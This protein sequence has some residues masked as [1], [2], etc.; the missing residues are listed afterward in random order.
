MRD[1]IFILE[2]HLVVI[3]IYII[4]YP[5]AP[6][7]SYGAGG[8]TDDI[9]LDNL[10]DL[11]LSKVYL[12]VN[13]VYEPFAVV[14]GRRIVMA[15]HLLAYLE[16]QDGIF[17]FWAIPLQ[18]VYQLLLLLDLKL[19]QSITLDP[20]KVSL[21]QPAFVG[22]IHSLDSFLELVFNCTHVSH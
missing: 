5:E 11:V 14:F 1:L 4:Q 19:D 6:R 16:S 12:I 7:A 18:K 9:S 17:T 8:D 21:L 22:A 2:D 20:L 15:V 13:R 10:Q 3:E